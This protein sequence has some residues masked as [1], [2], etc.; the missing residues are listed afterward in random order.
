[1]V[2]TSIFSLFAALAVCACTK[3]DTGIADDTGPDSDDTG[4]SDTTP[5][6]PPSDFET[7]SYR[8]TSMEILDTGEGYDLDGDGEVNNKLPSV[9]TLLDMA[10]E[11]DMS[12]DGLNTTI[13]SALEAGDLVQLID[14]SYLDLDLSYDLLLGDL[15][16][17]G[18]LVLDE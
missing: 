13:A 10:V 7:G 9:L 3:D 11:D 2:R 5:D 18:T 17:D 16:D 8:V 15:E 14:A 12:R 1:M 6:E 4:D